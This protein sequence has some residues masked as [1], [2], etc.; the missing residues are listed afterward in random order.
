[1]NFNH[2]PAYGFGHSKKNQIERTDRLYTPGP[3]T[4]A[5]RTWGKHMQLGK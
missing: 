1:M 4:Y 3:G 5:P 2:V